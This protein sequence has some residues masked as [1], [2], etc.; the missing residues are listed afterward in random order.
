[1]TNMAAVLWRTLLVGELVAA[2]LLALAVTTMSSLRAWIALPMV[3]GAFVLIQYVVVVGS[4]LTARAMAHESATP[5]AAGSLARATA[6]ESVSLCLVML[7]MGTEPWWQ[8]F[9]RA[10]ET[11]AAARRPVL[12]LHGFACNRGIWRWLV[13]RLQIAG[14]APIHALNLEPVHSDIDRLADTV[15]RELLKMH[16]ESGGVRITIIAH[17]MGGLVARATLRSLGSEAI[18]RLITLATPHHGAA[19]ARILPRSYARQLCPGSS[20]LAALNALQEGHWRVPVTSIYS[21]EDNLVV[22]VRSPV[23]LGAKLHEMHRLGHF[24]LLTT[25]RGLDCVMNALAERP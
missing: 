17:S 14:F 16:R 2:I 1:M 11:S 10:R 15:E 7:A 25:R 20:W 24:G 23:L 13:P 21:R 8:G 3:L 19:I 9:E 6:S 4:M 22:P 5:L 12:L 18:H